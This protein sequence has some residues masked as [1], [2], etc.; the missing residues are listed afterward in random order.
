VGRGFY[1]VKLVF[2]ILADFA[3]S[4][5]LYRGRIIKALVKTGFFTKNEFCDNL[6]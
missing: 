6:F 2:K 5:H 4:S 3:K 1:D